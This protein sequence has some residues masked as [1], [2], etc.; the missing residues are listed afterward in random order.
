MNKKIFTLASV[1]AFTASSYLMAA[2]IHPVSSSE[3]L[4]WN[5]AST[6]EENKV[7]TNE[8]FY[9]TYNNLNLYIDSDAVCSNGNYGGKD[10]VLT[11]TNGA[12]WKM[13]YVYPM[14]G[15]TW[16]FNAE[17]KAVIDGYFA[18]CNGA[19]DIANS[20]NL[21][22]NLDDATLTGQIQAWNDNAKASLSAENGSVFKGH[23]DFANKKNVTFSISFE[24]STYNTKSVIKNGSNNCTLNF[25]ILGSKNDIQMGSVDINAGTLLFKADD[26]GFSVLNTSSLVLNSSL[27]A[28]EVDFTEYSLTTNQRFDLITSVD[29]DLSSYTNLQTTFTGLKAGETANLAYDAL[30]KTLYVDYAVP[31]PSTYAAIFG[32]LALA[33]V[34]Y[35][36]RK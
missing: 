15:S 22:V 14:S 35:R 4:N 18:V 17:K 31:E 24:D 12:T 19:A 11:I 28:L 30:T 8:R 23:I 7:P 36:R 21:L 6:W 1:L 27:V 29:S 2:D 20:G 32:A 3:Q 34:A 9:T 33:F 26:A 16:T 5:D 10:N 13:G 25:S